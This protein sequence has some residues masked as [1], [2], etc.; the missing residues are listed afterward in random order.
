MTSFQVLTKEDTETLNLCKSMMER[1]E[2]PS[3]M[4][5]FDPHEGLVQFTTLFTIFSITITCFP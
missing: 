5:V 2:W 1:G 3:L 4:V